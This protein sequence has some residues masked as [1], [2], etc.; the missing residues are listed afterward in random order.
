[1]MEIRIRGRPGTVEIAMVRLNMAEVR[2]G[3]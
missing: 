3:M 1:M 2:H